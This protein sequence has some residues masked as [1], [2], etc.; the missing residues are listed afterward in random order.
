MG[1][2]EDYCFWSR[3]R[4]LLCGVAGVVKDSF[5]AE[6]VW[7]EH[8]VTCFVLR[9]SFKYNVAGSCGSDWLINLFG[10]MTSSLEASTFLF[11][12]MKCNMSISRYR[13]WSYS[14]LKLHITYCGC[15]NKSSEWSQQVF[16]MLNDEQRIMGL[17]NVARQ[18]KNQDLLT[19]NWSA[20]MESKSSACFAASFN[21]NLNWI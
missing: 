10:G 15:S 12:I 4:P 21:A 7:A 13:Y 2:P 1:M 5:T 6:E 14:C 20:V 11:F 19:L 17:Q 16:E 3:G 8:T 18:V 9:L